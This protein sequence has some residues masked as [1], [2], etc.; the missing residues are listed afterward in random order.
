MSH[1]DYTEQIKI[2]T[3]KRRR[4]ESKEIISEEA[5]AFHCHNLDEG[6]KMIYELDHI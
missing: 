2:A 5:H 3:R 1:W 6:G 4:L